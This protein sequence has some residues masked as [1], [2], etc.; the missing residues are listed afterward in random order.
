MS[1]WLQETGGDRGESYDERFRQLAASGADVHGE[2]DCVSRLLPSGAVLDAGCG[3]GRVAIELARR[4]YDVVGTDSDASML[5]VA[6]DRAPDLTW[7]LQDLVDLDD[8]QAYDLVVTAG[9][10]MVFVSEGTGPAVVA[11]MARALRPGAL[12][13]SGWQTE[14]AADNG[15]P[16]LPVTDYDAWATTAGL[17]RVA[18]WATWDSEPW[19]PTSGWCVAV[20]RAP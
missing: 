7:R 17:E 5:A 3:T 14:H 8:E 9:N 4:G 16:T 12:L 10:V 19:Q 18:R 20:D 11:A 15:R 2:A 1:R 13:V 6:R